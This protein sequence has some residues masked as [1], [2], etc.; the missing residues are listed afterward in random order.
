MEYSIQTRNGS[1]AGKFITACPSVEVSLGRYDLYKLEGDSREVRIK[2]LEGCVWITQIGDAD[3]HMVKA[4]QVFQV[5]RRGMVL[6][7]GMPA[8]RV[9]VQPGAGFK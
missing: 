8:G 6:I 3:D 1:K 9:R 5:E 7:Q 4:G 2:G